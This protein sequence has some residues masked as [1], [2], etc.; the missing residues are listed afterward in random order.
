M[1]R[2]VQRTKVCFAHTG[3]LGHQRYIDVV[4]D[5]HRLEIGVVFNQ[6]QLGAKRVR[7]GHDVLHGLQLGHIHAGFGRHVQVGVAGAQSCFLVAG[8]GPTHAAFAPVVGG[9]G[10]VPVAKHAMEFLQVVERGAG[11]GEHIAAVVA[12][13]VLL[14]VEIIAGGGHELPHAGGLGAGHRL[15]VEGTLDVGQQR[16][17]GGHAPQFELFN[18]VE[19]V[20]AGTLGHALHVIGAAGI[21]LL[22][23]LHQFVLQVGHG[24]A[25]ANAVPQV[26]GGGQRR[27]FAACGLAGRDRAQRPVGD[28]GGV[29]GS[30]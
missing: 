1:K 7:V 11:R 21:P 15:W 5:V 16:Q 19:Q 25:P 9:Q 14:E 10:Q 6:R 20:F 13:G 2:G 27:H 28:D 23:V 3:Q 30:A 12:K 26:G 29:V 22:A 8:N 18:N 17:F 4:G 24:K